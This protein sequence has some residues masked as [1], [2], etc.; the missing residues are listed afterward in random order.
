MKGGRGQ[1]AD[2]GHDGG[3]VGLTFRAPKKRGQTTHSKETT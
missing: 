1:T 3:W 2:I